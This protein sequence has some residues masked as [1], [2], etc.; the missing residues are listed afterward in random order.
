MAQ[1]NMKMKIFYTELESIKKE[2]HRYP[3]VIIY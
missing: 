2:L 1:I 3:K